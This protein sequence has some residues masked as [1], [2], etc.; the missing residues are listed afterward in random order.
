MAE[1]PYAGRDTVYIDPFLN[2]NVFAEPN[3]VWLCYCYLIGQY[4]SKNI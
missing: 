2:I 1:F 3:Y 4:I